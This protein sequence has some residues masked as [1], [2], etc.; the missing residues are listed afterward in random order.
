MRHGRLTLWIEGRE[1]LPVRAIPYVTNSPRFSPDMLVR[2][3][4]RND[5][6]QDGVPRKNWALEAYRVQG[7]FSVP[8]NPVEWDDFESRINRVR[9]A[10]KKVFSTTIASYAVWRIAATAVLPAGWYVIYDEFVKIWQA[11]QVGIV[12]YGSTRGNDGLILSPPMD[13]D[14]RAMVMEGFQ[15]FIEN[16]P[17]NSFGTLG[18]AQ[19]YQPSPNHEI[20]IAPNN[21]V[22]ARPTV[23]I[24]DEK[25]SM[26]EADLDTVNVLD[27]N[28][29]E[30]KPFKRVMSESKTVAPADLGE[31][32][33]DQ[34]LASLFDS[35]TAE[36]LEEM[37]P[38]KGKWKGWA[39]HAW[40]NGLAAARTSRAMFNPYKACIWFLG[41]GIEGWDLA[42]A[43]RRLANNLPL[44]S[45][46]K[47]YLLTGELD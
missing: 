43:L 13:A 35:V 38:A 46:D 33:H 39:D 11:D 6:F 19:Q 18:G 15:W 2:R 25:S 44:R 30:N 36:A 31:E 8:V 3:F 23:P 45:R 21:S 37:F 29:D 7:T 4:T 22:L 26:L 32:D 5:P 41:K 12:S 10:V 42:H 40:E 27:P 14:T 24:L 16:E 17:E 47:K 20:S 1:V 34:L 9:R 28:V